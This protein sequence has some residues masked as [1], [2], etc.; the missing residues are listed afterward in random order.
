[1]LGFVLGFWLLSLGFLAQIQSN[2][3]WSVSWV[4]KLAKLF[5]VTGTILWMLLNTVEGI[6]LGVLVYQWQQAS[7]EDAQTWFLIAQAVFLLS[8]YTLNSMAVIIYGVGIFLFAQGSKYLPQ[9]PKLVF[10][11]LAITALWSVYLGLSLAL[12]FAISLPTS[13]L[14]T[15][16]EAGFPL[17]VLALAYYLFRSKAD[18]P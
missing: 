7:S 17:L 4:G 2:A 15:L 3:Q 9:I 18:L 8:E 13:G 1:M 5:I 14:Q 16:V 6:G 12:T 10:W 11:L